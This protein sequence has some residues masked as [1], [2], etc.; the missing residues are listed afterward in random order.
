MGGQHDAGPRAVQTA[1][2]PRGEAH[3]GGGQVPDEGAVRASGRG[4]FSALHSFSGEFDEACGQ[5]QMTRSSAPQLHSTIPR[6]GAKLVSLVPKSSSLLL[7]Q[8]YYVI[9]V[10]LCYL[11]SM[12]Q[13][14]LSIVKPN[15]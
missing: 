12:S 2:Q 7:L 9:F 3:Q 6:L 1:D 5:R 15:V 8:L 10:I 14:S 11:S 13:M 4:R